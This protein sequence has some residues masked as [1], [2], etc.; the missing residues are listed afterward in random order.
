MPQQPRFSGGAKHIGAGANP[1]N[2]CGAFGAAKI[3]LCTLSFIR[4]QIFKNFLI[5]L[6]F[7]FSKRPVWSFIGDFIEILQNLSI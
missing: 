5:F 2:I 1:K 3:T 4:G 6:I 7:F